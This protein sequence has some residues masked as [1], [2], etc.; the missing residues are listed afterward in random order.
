MANIGPTTAFYKVETS[1][2]RTNYEANN[3]RER[4]ASGKRVLTLVIELPT[5]R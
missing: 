5:Q 2:T 3:S 1:L 4:I